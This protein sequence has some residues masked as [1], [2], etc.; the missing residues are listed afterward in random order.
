MYCFMCTNNPF[1]SCKRFC[2]TNRFA[3]AASNLSFGFG[4]GCIET[5]GMFAS[6]QNKASPLR[7]N[8]TFGAPS[9]KE[10]NLRSVL[11]WYLQKS[12][13]REIFICRICK[14]WFGDQV[15]YKVFL[16]VLYFAAF[17]NLKGRLWLVPVSTPKK[18]FEAHRRI[19]HLLRRNTTF[20]A[21]SSKEHNLRSADC[22]CQRASSVWRTEVWAKKYFFP[23]KFF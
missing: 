15:C 11:Y 4:N 14:S 3:L 21:P 7:R 16:C 12:D 6:A 22:S 5:G 2:T 20:G 1:V 8:T 10:H 19:E 23:H 18:L 9:S 17:S 13:V